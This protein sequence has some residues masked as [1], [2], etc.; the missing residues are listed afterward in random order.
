MKKIICFFAVLVC[1][2]NVLAV[3]NWTGSSTMWTLGDGTEE[4]PYIISSPAHLAYLSAQ[5]AAGQSFSGVFFKQTNDF[6]MKGTSY[7]FS[8]I[9]MS[10]TRPFS[11][12]YDGDSHYIENLKPSAYNSSCALFGWAKSASIQNIIIES[13][14]F[15]ATSSNSSNTYDNYEYDKVAAIAGYTE[16]SQIINCIN[17][18]DAIAY[19]ATKAAGIVAEAQSSVITDCANNG[20]ISNMA[21][22][23]TSVYDG[24]VF[25]S[26]WG[27]IVGYSTSNVTI[28][29]CVNTN[30]ISQAK[31]SGGILGYI[32]SDTELSQVSNCI[33]SGSCFAQSMVLGGIVGFSDAN[34]TITECGNTAR[35]SMN[36]AAA[37]PTD[38]NII[39]QSVGGICGSSQKEMIIINSYNSGEISYNLPIPSVFNLGGLI[40]TASGSLMI[41]NS[42][43]VGGISVTAK[44]GS[45]PN[46]QNTYYNNVAVGGIIGRASQVISIENTYNIGAISCT[47][48]NKATRNELGSG[49]YAYLFI[50]PY[51]GGIIGI[52]EGPST[53]L[54][55]CHNNG[56]IEVLSTGTNSGPNAQTDKVNVYAGGLVGDDYS[57]TSV[58]SLSY[59]YA[60][61]D[62]TA[63]TTNVTL[64]NVAGL[65]GNAKN[66][67]I[68]NSYY[69]GQLAGLTLGGIANGTL[70]GGSRNYYLSACG[71]PSG[72]GIAES[73]SVMKSST[74]PSSL[75]ET[76]DMI[77]GFDKE[78]VNHGYPIF[79]TQSSFTITWL[80]SDSTLIDQNSWLYGSTPTH[81]I[82]HKDSTAMYAYS[83]IGWTPTIVPVA[84]DATY[85]ATYDST[86]I[87]PMASG[88]CG[89]EGDGTN[90]TWE[91]SCDSVLTISGTGAMMNWDDGIYTPWYSYIEKITSIIISDNVTSIGDYAFYGCTNL[92]SVTI[93]NNVTSIGNAAFLDCDDLTSME[94]PNSVTSVGNGA[95]ES[96][97]SL[98]SITLP[99]NISSIGD[100]V[101]LGCTSLTSV[102]IP[103][104]VTNIGESAFGGCTNMTSIIIGNGVI[105]IGS[106]AFGGC[107]SLTVITLPQNVTTIETWAFAD[108]SNL[109]SVTIP[110]SVTS[111]GDNA[112]YRCSSLTNVYNNATTPQTIS[113]GVFSGVTLSACSLH[114]PCGSIVAYQTADV[115]K[116][117]GTIVGDLPIASGTCGEN[118]TWEL[119]CDS[120]LTISG[121]GA[122]IDY[123][124]PQYVPWYNYRMAINEVSISDGVAT[125]GN[126]AF[127]GC[128]NLKSLEIPN[129]VTSIGGN[130]FDICESLTNIIIPNIVTS[131]GNYA[132]QGC[133]GLTTVTIP[134][135]TISIGDGIFN[136]CS[137][138]T[139][140]MVANGNTVYDCRDNCNAIIETASNTLIA[141][142]QNTI[143]PNDVI[144]IGEEAFNGCT[145]LTSIVIPNSVT[146]IGAIAFELCTNLT[147]V[148]IGSGVTQIEESA[149]ADC[150][151]LISIYSYA[152]TPPIVSSY[153]FEGVTLSSGTLHVP[154]G[155]LAAYQAADVWKNFGTIVEEGCKHEITWLNYD[156]TI[157]KV[158]S[159]LEGETPSYS[160]E[161]PVKPVTVE[162]TYT[163]AGWTPEIV[164]VTEDA[165]YT[166]VFDSAKV[167]YHV[168][169]TIPDTIENNGTVI[170]GGTPTY[171]DTITLTAIPDDGY[172]F[173]SWS[174]GNTD[175][176]RVIV[177]TGDVE[178]YPIF[179]PCEP[180]T[181]NI[182]AT[183]Y[184]DGSYRVGDEV[185]T[186]RGT[187]RVTLSAANGC[188]SVVVLRLNVIKLPT[189]NVRVEVNNE[190]YG[191]A[192]GAG[193]YKKNQEATLTATP[194]S[195]GNRFTWWYNSATQEKVTANPYTFTVTED[196]L[197][198]AVF[199][200]AVK[201]ITIEYRSAPRRMTVD[202][203]KT[204]AVVSVSE[205]L[206]EIN[207][208]SGETYYLY[209]ASG[210][211]ITSSQDDKQY[212]LPSGMYIIRIEDQTEKFIVP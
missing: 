80:N 191:S 16:N 38:N 114:V 59:T 29:S 121:T 22:T 171:G 26:Y 106:S 192:S 205:K 119:S 132:F 64:C 202:A 33:N 72:N 2:S 47:A 91:L 198:R 184:D 61:C 85:I 98:K 200:R 144:R 141:G 107:A 17:N 138:L 161:T 25:D 207:N 195:K 66:T 56:N 167:E 173:D 89:G 57:N 35:L 129:S 159:L 92:V 49:Q 153:T 168:D 181:T 37:H 14:T 96:C 154:C 40:G 11:G 93:P 155:S 112:F 187:Y 203:D 83:F 5:V 201:T 10:A 131:I 163:F 174:D 164:P 100:E 118:L 122:M 79:D 21:V 65:I 74:F 178:V 20:V 212:T 189:Y 27:G 128:R 62:V 51:V 88:Y 135:S 170:I 39:M 134:S 63:P 182:T 210:K 172:Y 149:F 99:N 52:N 90:L 113:S 24:A 105:S 60:V 211:L 123:G 166:A 140:I 34:I 15:I 84:G 209:D 199:S 13:I 150:N 12:N 48:V 188:D 175:N 69:A 179:K 110:N 70:T 169:V 78:L 158:D 30:G 31:Y 176:P 109:M 148:T 147:S 9:G 117:L 8:P 101:F 152:I 46:L 108:C 76:G 139:S 206:A 55:R 94:I 75:N 4:S 44:D 81:E 45:W 77:F 146:N 19:K 115:W 137:A 183:I 53:Q 124:T 50:R 42:Y 145:G 197:W 111:I 73:E 87:C 165:T 116:D 151:S 177:V 97:S 160:G 58:C 208:I 196:V 68:N 186:T 6:D 143:I 1:I 136:G 82:P 142:C 193:I 7:S 156:R 194:K 103:H 130:A 162:Y 157:L 54:K 71:A 3:V 125:I 127:S 190:L 180:I 67:I 18:A 102:E 126:Y 120:V 23:N 133:S 28:S 43:N 41:S 104:S 95:F 32:S 36:F 185:F 204:Y 86:R